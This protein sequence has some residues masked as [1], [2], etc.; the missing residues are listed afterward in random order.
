M[1]AKPSIG[2]LS[3]YRTQAEYL[4]KTIANQISAGDIEQHNIRVGT[5]YQFQGEER[6]IMLLSFSV[7]E[8]SLNASGYLNREDVFNVAITRAKQ[9]QWVFVSVSPEKLH[10]NNLLRQYIESPTQTTSAK[11]TSETLDYFQDVVCHHL[12]KHQITTWKGYTIAGQTMDIL[13]RKH[14]K[15]V[16]IDLIGFPGEWQD[17]YDTSSY[18]VFR[19]AG[20]TVVPI[21]YADWIENSESCLSSVLA[22]L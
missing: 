13:C 3:P 6:D 8:N 19:R 16:A 12:A 22:N 5:P 1:K 9:K 20:L 11:E 15:F 10:I 4:D 2:V 17:F 14:E 7:C 18:K 21:C